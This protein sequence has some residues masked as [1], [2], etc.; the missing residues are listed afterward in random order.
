MGLLGYEWILTD[1]Q[2][3]IL[4][5]NG[6]LPHKWAD[7]MIDNHWGYSQGLQQ[8]VIGI[9]EII[10]IIGLLMDY[11]WDTMNRYGIIIN[12]NSTAQGGDE[13]A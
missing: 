4:W 8:V 1:Y 9:H 12:T 11:E 13:V 10:Q 6:L 5:I 7:T 2:L 3:I